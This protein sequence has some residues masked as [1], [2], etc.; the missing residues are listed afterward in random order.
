M[1]EEAHELRLPGTTRAVQRASL[2]FVVS[3]RVAERPVDLG[4]RVEQGAVLARLDPDP[5]QNRAQAA[6]ATLAEVR[7]RLE[8]TEREHQRLTRLHA[9]G[10][11]SRRDL[12]N[13]AATQEGLR[14][15]WALARSRLREARRQLA[16]AELAA[17][18]S[19]TVTSVHLEPGEYAQ[20]GASVITLSGDG[21]LE[22]EVEVPEAVASKL[23]EGEGA[24][25]SFPMNGKAPVP[26]RLTSVSRG[27][28][29]PGRLFPVVAELETMSGLLPGMAGELVLRAR[30]GHR[31]AVPL[32]SIIDPSGKNPC[33]FRIRDGRAQRVPV[34]VGALIG[35]R[36][37]V[38]AG[39]ETGDP[40]VVAGHGVL[41]DGDPVEI[42]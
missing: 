22:L 1:L 37:T 23:V 19:G 31:L 14:A 10:V 2:S 26:A 21:G 35:D 29:G 16:E 28:E 36:I 12:E 11:A 13:G 6:E 38:T 27:T 30:G 41:L 40:I 24:Q 4:A 15:S 25:V 34:E 9:G 32:A 7:A 17:P 5:F 39:L 42:R 18:F 8:Q 3:G 33:V 20:A